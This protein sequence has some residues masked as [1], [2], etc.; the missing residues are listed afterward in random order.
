LAQRLFSRG[1][2]PDL[3]AHYCEECDEHLCKECKPQHKRNKKTKDHLLAALDCVRSASPSSHDEAE[4]GAEDVA[5]QGGGC[6][7]PS[8]KPKVA[9]FKLMI[10]LNCKIEVAHDNIKHHPGHLLTTPED[11]VEIL[12]TRSAAIAAGIRNSEEIARAKEQEWRDTKTEV[13][14]RADKL[15]ALA[16]ALK[17]EV[18]EQHQMPATP[19]DDALHDHTAKLRQ[20]QERMAGAIDKAAR[21]GCDL[22]NLLECSRGTGPAAAFQALND[23]RVSTWAPAPDTSA[24]L[25]AMLQNTL[26]QEQHVALNP[27][28]CRAEGPGLQ[29][30][31]TCQTG[32]FVVTV[33]NPAGARIPRV[34]DTISVAAFIEG[35]GASG[36]GAGGGAKAGGPHD[37]APQPR[38]AVRVGGVQL[39]PRLSLECRVECRERDGSYAISYEIPALPPA[40]RAVKVEVRINGLVIFNPPTQRQSLEEARDKETGCGDAAAKGGWMGRNMSAGQPFFSVSVVEG[41]NVEFEESRPFEGILFNLATR[42]RRQEWENPHE[43]KVVQVS[44]TPSMQ[45][46]QLAAFVS[47]PNHL[48]NENYTKEEAAKGKKSSVSVDLK[49]WELSPSYYSIRNDATLTHTLR[50]WELQ[51]YSNDAQD[52]H[53]LTTHENMTWGEDCR[54]KILSFPVDGRGDF[55]RI[56]RIQMVCGF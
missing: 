25:T 42:F 40:A 9:P 54:F 10:C 44:T 37:V 15:I 26:R 4:A 23:L 24:D 33:H 52:W 32:N 21:G 19:E 31:Y 13:V 45:R 30:I 2:A 7:S 14:R 18:L 50:S 47:G 35:S 6:E 38:G 12:H 11:E 55:Y 39:I 56:F 8:K 20:A 17:R 41:C 36:G 51:A 5:P 22:A 1:N 48:D 53:T 29:R 3:S 28:C 49:T 16:K 27:L 34:G 43:T 46:G